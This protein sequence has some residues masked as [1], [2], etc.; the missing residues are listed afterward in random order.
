MAVPKHRL[1]ASHGCTST[2][3]VRIRRKV[4]YRYRSPVDRTSR[5]LILRD[6]CNRN[7]SS[8]GDRSKRW[9][10]WS[11]RSGVHDPCSANQ[12]TARRNASPFGTIGRM[13]TKIVQAQVVMRIEGCENGSVA[14][15]CSTRPTPSPTRTATSLP[16]RWL[17]RAPQMHDTRW[18]LPAPSL[19]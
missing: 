8:A 5:W 3:I 7:S 1:P 15:D 16:N 17:N 14:R 11:M 2:N 4:L 13:E 9:L 6:S 18:G 19:G 10:A 12:A